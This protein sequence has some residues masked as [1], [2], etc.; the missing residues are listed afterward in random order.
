MV[1]TDDDTDALL[2]SV[3]N[4]K[5]SAADALLERHRER[6]TAMV[7]LRMDRRLAARLD[8]SDVV[9]DTLAEAYKKL[10]KFA[11]TR[12]MP[13]YPWLRGIAWERLIQL[14]RQHVGADRRSVTREETGTELC[15]GSQLLL[16]DRLAASAASVSRHAMRDEI[17]DRVRA[18]VRQLCAARSRNRDPPPFGG[19]AVQ[20]NHR[21]PRNQRGRGLL[22]LPPGHGATRPLAKM[23][24]VAV[25]LRQ[26]ICDAAMNR[27]SYTEVYQESVAD[28]EFDAL[29]CRVVGQVEAGQ[30]IDFAAIAADSPEHADRL[31]ELLPTL[32]AMVALRGGESLLPAAGSNNPPPRTP[33]RRLAVAGGLESS[34]PR[35]SGEGPGEGPAPS[36]TSASSASSAAAAWASSTRRS[37]SRSA[38]AS[39]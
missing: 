38:A 22:A 7:R 31:R 27:L 13:F 17:R 12:P 10:R 26:K 36:A 24:R 34:P 15:D 32:Q 4:G 30:S 5:Q 18:A 37:K 2:A 28:P 3:A 6:L 25:Y 14:H 9:Q 39:P 8:A 35:Y 23:R 16:A 1:T 33:G 29:F 20:R 19:T 21:R 11:A